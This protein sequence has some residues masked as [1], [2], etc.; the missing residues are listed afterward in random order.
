[1]LRDL[2]VNHDYEPTTRCQDEVIYDQVEDICRGY[3]NVIAN[4]AYR[5]PCGNN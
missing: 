3:N 1:M 4:S 2:A 5:V